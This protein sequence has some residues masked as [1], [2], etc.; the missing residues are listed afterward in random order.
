MVLRPKDEPSLLYLNCECCDFCTIWT[1]C[2]STQFTQATQDAFYSLLHS[3]RKMS[4]YMI[5]LPISIFE[6]K[7]IK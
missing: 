5:S 4:I 6:L 3:E 7:L 2:R 1:E